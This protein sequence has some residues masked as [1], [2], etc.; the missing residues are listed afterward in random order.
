MKQNQI[1]EISISY[2]P[3]HYKHTKIQSSEDAYKMLKEFFTPGE[4]KLQLL[5]EIGQQ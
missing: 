1:A 3:S 5:L 4:R 2:T